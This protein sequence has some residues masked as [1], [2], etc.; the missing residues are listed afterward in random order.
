MV[1]KRHA[2][3]I[4]VGKPERKRSRRPGSRW[5]DNIRIDHREIGESV[6]T[7]LIWLRIRTSGKLL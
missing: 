5:D 2:Y 6:W 7:V 4:S 1:E 3:N